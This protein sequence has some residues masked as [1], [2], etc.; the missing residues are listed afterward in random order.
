MVLLLGPS[1]VPT[2]M[3]SSLHYEVGYSWLDMIHL[4][5]IEF[6]RLSCGISCHA[7]KNTAMA[8]NTSDGLRSLQQ[9]VVDLNTMCTHILC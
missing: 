8:F 9:S 6:L 2:E 7:L 5:Q 3:G 4:K 1:H